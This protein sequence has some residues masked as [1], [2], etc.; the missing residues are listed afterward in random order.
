MISMTLFPEVHDWVVALIVSVETWFSRFS[1]IQS[2]ISLGL[3]LCIQVGY[4]VGNTFCRNGLT[5]LDELRF[6]TWIPVAGNGHGY[7]IQRCLNLFSHL[8]ITTITRLTFFISQVGTHLT[9]QNC[10]NILSNNGVKAPSLLNKD[11]P[12]FNCSIAFP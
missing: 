5:L 6:K 3:F 2:L 12:V 11:L 4:T 10:I 1:S 7:F 9:F 8:V